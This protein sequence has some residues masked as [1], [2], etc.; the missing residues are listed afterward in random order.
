[1]SEKQTH[2]NLSSAEELIYVKVEVIFYSIQDALSDKLCIV[3]VLNLMYALKKY[4][5]GPAASPS[6]VD[7]AGYTLP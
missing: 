5:K 2:K 6:V 3:R 4:R 1:M 7:T